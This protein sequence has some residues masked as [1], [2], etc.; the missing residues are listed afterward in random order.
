MVHHPHP[1][2]IVV[3]VCIS[4]RKQ[5]FPVSRHIKKSRPERKHP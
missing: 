3:P 2:P 4:T 1:F 5:P